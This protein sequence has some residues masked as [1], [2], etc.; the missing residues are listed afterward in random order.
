LGGF[1]TCT[2]CGKEVGLG[3]SRCWY[4]GASSGEPDSPH[5]YVASDTPQQ[6]GYPYSI[7]QSTPDVRW[8]GGE[9]GLLFVGQRVREYHVLSVL[10]RGGMAEVYEAEHC[11]TRQR[12]ALKVLLPGLARDGEVRM[13][14][15]QEAQFLAA[16]Q[17]PNILTFRTLIEESG[18]L[19]LVLDFIDGPSLDH[20]LNE[21]WLD[22]DEATAVS[23]GV[24]SALG[25]AHSR[26]E[27][28]VHRDI[29]PANILFTNDGE[30]MVADFGIARA[31]GKKGATRVGAV[32][33]TY[34]YMSP[35]QTRGETPSPASDIYS[36]GITL[37]RML[38]GAVP[39]KQLT[40]AGYEVMKAHQEETPPALSEYRMGVP[41]WLERFL[42]VCLQKN[43]ERRFV[44]GQ[45]AFE[46]LRRKWR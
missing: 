14:F 35:E 38:T 15:V 34:E 21:R 37:Y 33:G 1:R 16:L 8:T 28:I 30:P 2:S 32:L 12:V 17:H 9:Q 40:E 43:P 7:W 42:V 36:Y 46:F 6:P 44:D 29:K 39:F 3:E 26:R 13:R 5:T 27:K 10:P 31:V 22:F 45:E 4:C 11:L 18:L 19:I 20:V 41:R 25:Y 23:L 24:L